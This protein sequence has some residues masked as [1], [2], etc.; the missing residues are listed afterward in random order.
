[1]VQ[2]RKFMP[3]DII[4]IETLPAGF[5]A[6]YKVRHSTPGRDGTTLTAPLKLAVRADKCWCTLETD[7]CE[8]ATPDEALDRMAAWLR[9]LADGIE[10]RKPST[11]I[12]LC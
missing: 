5:V 10:Q 7:E 4:T 8:A 1:M 12:P 11:S 6:Q 9:R 3:L 2:L